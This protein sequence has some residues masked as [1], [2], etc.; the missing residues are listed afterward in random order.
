MSKIQ[1]FVINTMCMFCGSPVIMLSEHNFL[2]FSGELTENTLHPVLL[3][4]A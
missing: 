2:Q 1:Y 4:M 3:F